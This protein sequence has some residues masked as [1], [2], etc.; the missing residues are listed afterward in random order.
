MHIEKQVREKQLNVF[1]PQFRAFQRKE[2]CPMCQVPLL[3]IN[4]LLQLLVQLFF[5]LIFQKQYSSV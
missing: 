5:L 1:P 2:M 4:P 3:S